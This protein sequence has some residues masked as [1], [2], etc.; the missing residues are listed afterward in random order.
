MHPPASE[1]V[2]GGDL[3][4]WVM[5][6]MIHSAA[7]AFLNGGYA[8]NALKGDTLE[9]IADIQGIIVPR[10]GYL[11]QGVFRLCFLDLGYI[12]L[13]VFRSEGT[14][15]NGHDYI[16]NQHGKHLQTGGKADVCSNTWKV[17]RPFQV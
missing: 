9:G 5:D 11:P 17:G 15:L 13:R 6:S 2:P 7:H 16:V 4:P 1:T 10:E 3:C 14:V 8:A 12:K